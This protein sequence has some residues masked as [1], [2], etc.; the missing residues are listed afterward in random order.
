MYPGVIE[1]AVYGVAV[2]NHDGRAGMAALVVESMEKFDLPSL[3]AFLAEQLPA[4]AR[5]QFLRFRTELD[6]TSTFRARKMDLVADG[7]DPART[8][9]P[10]YYDDRNAGAYV[11]VGETLIAGLNAGE[12]RL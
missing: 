2:P 10:V 7:F 6:T 3:R 1:A 8:A 9:D 12:I 4:F 11:R 5:P